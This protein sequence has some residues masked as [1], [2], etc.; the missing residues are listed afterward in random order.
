MQC[1]YCLF[2]NVNKFISCFF[3]SIFLLNHKALWIPK[4]IW[5]PIKKLQKKISWSRF[6]YFIH[7]QDWKI[8]LLRWKIRYTI[9]LEY[10]LTKLL[11]CGS[12]NGESNFSCTSCCRCLV[13]FRLEH[14]LHGAAW[15]EF[16]HTLFMLVFPVNHFLLFNA[17]KIISSFALKFNSWLAVGMDFLSLSRHIFSVWLVK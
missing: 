17:Y 5:F 7:T 14:F 4:W 13:L 8:V 15:F 11:A 1:R 3:L 2:Y 9:H 6:L 12:K 16:I 10:S